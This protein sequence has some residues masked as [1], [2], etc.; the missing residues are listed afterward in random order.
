MNQRSLVAVLI[1]AAAAGLVTTMFFRA[2]ADTAELTRGNACKTMNAD[3]VPVALRNREAPD[4]EL[5]DITGKKWSLRSLRGHTV[6]VHFWATWCPP[7]VEEMPALEDMTRVLGDKVVVLA[8]S[9]DDDW[10]AVKRF[11]PKGTSLPVLLDLSKQVPKSYG[12][13]KYPESYVIGPDGQVRHY[14]INNRK[15]GEPEATACLESVR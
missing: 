10:D 9:L 13:D 6:L 1:V 12:T 11:F 8:I 14:F 2:A 7:C 15:W 5:P 4:F 3:P